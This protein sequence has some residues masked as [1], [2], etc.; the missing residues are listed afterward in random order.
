MLCVGV[1]EGG[2]GVVQIAF[3]T[4]ETAQKMVQFKVRQ[5]NGLSSLSREP[6]RHKDS[7]N[8]Y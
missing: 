2:V 7:T 3:Y 4:K 8:M 5:A 1:G 6:I